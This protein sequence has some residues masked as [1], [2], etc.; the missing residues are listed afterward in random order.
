MV[1]LQV[2][3]GE[4]DVETKLIALELLGKVNILLNYKS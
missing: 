2:T 4:T 3:K 1:A